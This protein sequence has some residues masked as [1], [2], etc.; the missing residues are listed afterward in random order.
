MRSD[1]GKCQV[2]ERLF[3][4]SF[5]GLNGTIVCDE[6]RIYLYRTGDRTTTYYVTFRLKV[7]TMLDGGSHGLLA[8]APLFLFSTMNETRRRL[9]E[10]E[11][12]LHHV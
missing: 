7:S 11:V 3:C 10:V 1:L 5:D 4:L 9:K 8:R 12:H 2:R 6:H